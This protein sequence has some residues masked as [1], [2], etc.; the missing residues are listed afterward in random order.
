VV[1]PGDCHRVGF[2]GRWQLASGDTV[3]V[4][5]GAIMDALELECRLLIFHHAV[6]MLD[7]VLRLDAV[8]RP[9]LRVE[10]IK[11]TWFPA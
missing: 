2:L 1:V 5:Q 3:K 4:R 10:R 8:L 6:L 7:T 11:S 9:G